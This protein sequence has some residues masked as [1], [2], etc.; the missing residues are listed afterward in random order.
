MQNHAWNEAQKPDQDPVQ[1]NAL[2]NANDAPMDANDVQALQAATH[3]LQVELSVLPR[4]GSLRRL[5]VDVVLSGRTHR[6]S[7]SL[8]TQDGR[9]LAYHTQSSSS[10]KTVCLLVH[11]WVA[12]VVDA[13]R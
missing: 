13:S 6:A 12:G 3:A 9:A 10:A 4:R 5:D 11:G 7:V 2:T 1:V 8:T